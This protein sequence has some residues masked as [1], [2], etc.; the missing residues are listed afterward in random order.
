MQKQA[1]QMR[2]FKKKSEPAK[3]YINGTENPTSP[4]S[5]K[6]KKKKKP[7]RFPPIEKQPNLLLQLGYRH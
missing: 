7:H 6:E 5:E 3:L 1:L 2:L 4:E